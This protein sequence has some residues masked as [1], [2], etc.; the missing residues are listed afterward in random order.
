MSWSRRAADSLIVASVVGTASGAAQG[1]R[2]HF[3]VG[4]G[5]TFPSGAY[6]AD[7][8]G[9]GVRT[10]WQGTVFLDLTRPRSPVGIRV[11]A[12]YGANKSNAAQFL[13]DQ[14]IRMLGGSVDLTY[15]LPIS[16]SVKPYLLT[17]AGL[18]NVKLA[19]TSNPRDTSATKLSWNAGG[20][21]RYGVHGATLFV[22][23][24]YCRV[25]RL[26]SVTHRNYSGTFNRPYGLQ[27]TQ[28]GVAAG[29][30]FGGR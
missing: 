1:M 20:G 17:G 29:A 30:W 23:A 16:G 7:P 15:D 10:G 5:M 18:Y 4:G 2:P 11:E 9:D 19:Y 26:L 3:G 25:A 21:V 6:H 12:T 8:I 13:P 22:E 14:R 24:R 28:V 27:V